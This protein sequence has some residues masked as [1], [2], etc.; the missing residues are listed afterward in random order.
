MSRSGHTMLIAGIGII[1]SIVVFLLPST[2]GGNRFRHE[3]H[4][5][6]LQCSDCHKPAQ[7]QYSFPTK[8][9]CTKCHDDTEVI[10]VSSLP[11]R[12]RYQNV[13][14]S[15]R[16]H[17]DI[18]CKACHGDLSEDDPKI[19]GVK[20]CF[21]CHKEKAVERTC[22]D[23]HG[24]DR[25]FPSYH[26]PA[27]KWKMRHGLRVNTMVLPDREPWNIVKP[28]HVYDCSACH[29]D[30]A[31]RKCHQLNRPKNHTG[32]W[33]IR[34]HGIKALAQRESCSN[35]HVETFCIRCHQNTRPIN[36]VANWRHTHG[37]AAG[38]AHF[39][40]CSVCHPRIITRVH[41]GASPQCTFCH[42]Q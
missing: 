20:E 4:L 2:Y 33:R 37:R 13:E 32:F 27:G 3:A 42:P 6:G 7:D 30:D 16:S 39:E 38:G 26:K 5:E 28:G 35:C 31:C 10:E 12:P 15:H 11:S 23:C 17:T 22:K 1:L 18:E 36:H 8:A 14:L 19:I 21:E 25:F 24:E 40:R 29:V 34:G 9:L 41:V